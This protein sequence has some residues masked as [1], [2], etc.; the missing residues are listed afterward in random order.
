M[1]EYAYQ[2]IVTYR[3]S[4][5][6]L[7]CFDHFGGVLG[8]CLAFARVGWGWVIGTRFLF[9]IIEDKIVFLVMYGCLYCF[10]RFVFM[11]SFRKI[12]KLKKSENE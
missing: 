8:G 9:H 1:L 2:S 3:R 6:V 11:S 10:S 4:T 7:A 12:K 5:L